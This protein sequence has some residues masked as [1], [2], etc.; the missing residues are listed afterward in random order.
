[1]TVLS[2][3]FYPPVATA[4]C[5]PSFV[6]VNADGFGN[7][8]NDYTW[9]QAVFGDYLY[10]GTYNRDQGGEI[11]RY[12]GATWSQVVSA[13]FNTPENQ[14]FRNL[15]V[16]NGYLHTGTLN[17]STGA[18]LLRSAD[19]VTWETVMTGG[20]GNSDLES[21]RG[22]QVFAGYIYVGLQ[23]TASGPGELWRSADGV[24]YEPINVDGF[25]D[26]NNS[27]P[28][29]MEVFNGEL[30]IATRHRNNPPG[31]Y[32]LRSAD[33]LTFETVVGP[34]AA[35]PGA[36]GVAGGN[37]ASLDMH[38]HTDGYLYIG[39]VRFQGFQIW[40]TQDGISYEPVVGRGFND[41]GNMYA[42]RFIS[43][44]GYLWV[45]TFNIANTLFGVK[46]GTIWR[47]QNGT[48]W[49]EMVG[50]NGQ[51]AGYGFDDIYNWGIRSFAEYQGKLYIGTANNFQSGVANGTEVWEWPGEVCE[52]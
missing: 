50:R 13:G 47:T 15:V 18:E 2:G 52:P 35:T 27:S 39:T 12:D 36:F 45:G 29:T 25:G 5:D 31:L 4:A 30:Y 33:G 42:W 7:N 24:N 37:R 1:M 28:H 21:V 23:N 26:T 9:S 11:W 44:E 16:F 48:A 32:I 6:Q 17:E 51:Y 41:F 19:G 10:A 3:A 40:R 8:Q 20:F 49:T 14:G 43:Y 46:G 22:M 38:A 34:G